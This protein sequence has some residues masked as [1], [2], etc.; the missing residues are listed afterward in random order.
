MQKHSAMLFLLGINIGYASAV[1]AFQA[2][3]NASKNTFI[4][5][6]FNFLQ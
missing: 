3:Q 2:D 1:K 4:P 6:S 5:E